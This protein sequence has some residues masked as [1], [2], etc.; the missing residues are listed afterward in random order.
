MIGARPTRDPPTRVNRTSISMKPRPQSLLYCELEYTI[1]TA[2][3]EYIRSQLSDRNLRAAKLNNV[4]GSWAS[5]G[6]PNVVGFRYDLETQ[7]DLLEM[8]LDEFMFYTWRTENS[9]N[10]RGVL[11]SIRA[12][13]R[14]MRARTYCAPDAVIQKHLADAQVLL[15]IINANEAAHL[16]IYNCFRVFKM[17]REEAEDERAQEQQARQGNSAADDSYAEQSDQ[18]QRPSD[19]R[20]RGRLRTRTHDHVYDLPDDSADN[21]RDEEPARDD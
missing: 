3:D 18:P 9:A 5:R 16:M 4:A 2:L 6:R 15:D 10:I 17:Y 7:I 8:H 21:D 19:E 11:H 1:S 12:S 14:E 20:P 13:A